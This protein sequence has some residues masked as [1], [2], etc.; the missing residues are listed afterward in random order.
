MQ[1]FKILS[2]LSLVVSGGN[3]NSAQGSNNG[4]A[5]GLGAASV[6]ADAVAKD[7]PG[8]GYVYGDQGK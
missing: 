8:A 1:N 7:A 4:K 6:G 5:A 3:F 2:Y